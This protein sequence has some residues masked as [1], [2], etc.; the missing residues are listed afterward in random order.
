MCI[1]DSLLVHEARLIES[2]VM[3]A[4]SLQAIKDEIQKEVDKSVEFAE[5]S[6]FPEVEEMLLDVYSKREPS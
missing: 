5:E 1:R 2:G 6:P 3:S 4:D